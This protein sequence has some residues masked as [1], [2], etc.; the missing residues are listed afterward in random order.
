MCSTPAATARPPTVFLLDPLPSRLSS[1][2]NCRD[3]ERLV[4]AHAGPAATYTRVSAKAR[5]RRAFTLPA[6]SSFALM[7]EG[8]SDPN[9]L[10]AASLPYQDH[11]AS[12]PTTK[13]PD[14][15]LK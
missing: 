8:S 14:C 2:F 7:K 5:P 4:S 13:T 10:V 3:V 6:L 1:S 9:G 12:T 11:W 15:Q